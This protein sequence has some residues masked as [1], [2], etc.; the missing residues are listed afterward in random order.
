MPAT[1]RDGAAAVYLPACVNRIFGSADGEPTVVE[2]LVSISARAGKPVWIPTDAVGH[3][4]ATPWSSKGYPQAEQ[5]MSDKTGAALMRWSDGG[6]LPIVVDASSC[7]GA[8]RE[9]AGELEILDSV[10]WV[11]RLL[12]DLD[13]PRVVSLAVHPTCS[14]R[15][16]DQTVTLQRVA[17]AL[18]DDVFVPPSAYCCGFAGDRGMLHPE[19]TAAA[20][21]PEA[22]E[23][24]ARPF[25]AYVSSNRTCEIGLQ[26]GT[27]KPYRS[28]V[29]LVEE[30]LRSG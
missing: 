6:R 4:C 10:E 16:M 29:Q 15:H 28:V 14:T 20:T 21:A 22:A 24:N 13:V 17:E 25:D 19:L 5:Y 30:Q 3:C 18:A 26:Q 27:G 23:V 11:E 1:Q 9:F 12:A 2:A 8:I 7:S